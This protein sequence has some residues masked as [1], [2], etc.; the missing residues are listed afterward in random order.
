MRM[1]GSQ[2]VGLRIHLLYYGRWGVTSHG[3]N[4]RL[5]LERGLLFPNPQRPLCQTRPEKATG[6]T[7]A[8]G[9]SLLFTERC[10]C[11]TDR[12]HIHTLS[13]TL[14]HKALLKCYCDECDCYYRRSR[15]SLL[16]VRVNRTCF[17]C[18]GKS[19]VL[20]GILSL[21]VWWWIVRRKPQGD[22]V[23]GLRFLRRVADSGVVVARGEPGGGGCPLTLTVQGGRWG[24]T[25]VGAGQRG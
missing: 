1:R 17:V 6:I 12:Y 8:C 4:I 16:S 24:L 3:W 14:G 18:D 25:G 22:Q 21:L 23:M 7:T 2:P 11:W 13:P 20:V 15:L 9:K 5:P 10:C 19:T